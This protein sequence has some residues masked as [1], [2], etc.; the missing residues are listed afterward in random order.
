MI[1]ILDVGPIL[2]RKRR[3]KERKP[4]HMTP[5]FTP[6]IDY[7]VASFFEMV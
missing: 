1:R 2:L 3:K 4:K 6:T 5:M 7:N